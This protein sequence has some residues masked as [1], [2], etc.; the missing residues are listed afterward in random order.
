[1]L[2]HQVTVL[3]HA[4]PCYVKHHLRCWNL[5][6]FCRSHA[7]SLS[8]DQLPTATEYTE[9]PAV[10]RF[11]N[12]NRASQ[13]EAAMYIYDHINRS[14]KYMNHIW[15][16]IVYDLHSS[17]DTYVYI[18]MYVHVPLHQKSMHLQRFKKT[19]RST[20]RARNRSQSFRVVVLSQGLQ[21][22]TTLCTLKWC[23]F[24]WEVIGTFHKPQL[25]TPVLH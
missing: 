15:Y 12:H 21:R 2:R 4:T 8:S 24:S 7:S 16:D 1:M 11:Q 3:R 20:Q 10:T 18:L 14:Y 6:Q 13:F 17:V 9:S 19:T 22:L 23:P 5:H 25:A